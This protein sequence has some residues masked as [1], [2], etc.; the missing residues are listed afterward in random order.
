MCSIGIDLAIS[1][2]HL[3]ALIMHSLNARWDDLEV[4]VVTD[5]IAS[6]EVMLYRIRYV[7]LLTIA[8]IWLLLVCAASKMTICSL[9]LTL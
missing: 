6:W 3:N 1:L 8:S 7:T 5:L 4:Q 9:G 2:G